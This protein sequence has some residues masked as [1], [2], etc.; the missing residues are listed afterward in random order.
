MRMIFAL[1]YAEGYPTAYHVP[2]ERWQE[3]SRH[4]RYPDAL[5]AQRKHNLRTGGKCVY[6]VVP[7][8]DT[9]ATFTFLCQGARATDYRCPHN[10]HE[11]VT[12]PWP[13]GTPYPLRPTLPRWA[14]SNLCMACANA[15]EV[16]DTHKKGEEEHALDRR[17]LV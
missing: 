10:A 12:V 11:R 16:A 17:T 4:T 1:Q 7:L 9:F 8:R 2:A 5:I 3:A 14:A 6:R 15:A 13:A